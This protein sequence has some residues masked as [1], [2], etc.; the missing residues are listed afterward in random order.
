MKSIAYKLLPFL[1]TAFLIIACA[2]KK[3]SEDISVKRGEY[4]VKES[5]CSYCHTPTVESNGEIIVDDTRMFSGHPETAPV[6]E[7][8]NVDIESDEWIEFLTTLD[9]TV[10][11]GDWGMTFSANITPDKETG[12]G[13]WDVDTFIKTMRR[14]KHRGI[15]RNIQPPMPWK[16]FS[17][18]SDDELS[19]VFEYLQ[20]QKPVRNKVPNP[21][22]FTKY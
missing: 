20:T 14:G 7:I 12:I 2:E 17:K 5:N 1:L 6:P 3:P 11:A 9:S 8:P 15:G 16:D 10:W 19:S 4:L 13:K 18:L 21:I 22:I